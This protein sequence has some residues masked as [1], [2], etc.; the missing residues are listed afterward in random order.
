MCSLYRSHPQCVCVLNG[1]FIGSE[2]TTVARHSKTGTDVLP[3]K[4]IPYM[5]MS[6]HAHV[7][8]DKP[9]IPGQGMS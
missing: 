8:A 3:K 4:A 9:V 6:T 1:V 7:H 5:Y 2:I